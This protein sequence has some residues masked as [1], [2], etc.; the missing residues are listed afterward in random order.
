M[1]EILKLENP[2]PIPARHK[3]CPDCRLV[4]PEKDF[5]KNRR[6]GDGLQYYCRD[7]TAARGLASRK[8]HPARH[9]A[10]LHRHYEKN[11]PKILGRLKQHRKRRCE[12]LLARLKAD[13]CADCG[14]L[15]PPCAM[16][17]DH[18]PGTIKLFQFGGSALVRHSLEKTLAEIAKCDLV[19]ANCHR[20]RT[21]R[22][23]R[24][25]EG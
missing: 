7:C 2:P 3:K 21:W 14:N 15:F 5:G 13:P 22:R 17:F 25:G 20:V 1:G 11:K 9:K 18:R 10:T 8:M 16:D 6:M 12:E 4:K 24:E 19:C 23:R